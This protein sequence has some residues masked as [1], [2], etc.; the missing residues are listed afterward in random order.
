MQ[1]EPLFGVDADVVFELGDVAEG[2]LLDGGFAEGEVGGR[3]LLELHEVFAAWLAA[4]HDEEDGDLC[5]EGE[6][7]WPLEE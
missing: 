4:G 3:D 1:P 5:F 7:G 2:E 6:E